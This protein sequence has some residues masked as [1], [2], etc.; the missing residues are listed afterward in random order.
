MVTA[1]GRDDEQLAALHAEAERCLLAGESGPADA[2]LQA[3]SRR[4]RRRIRLEE[5]LLFPA[6]ADRASGAVLRMRREHAVLMEL[7]TG[8]ERSFGAGC[9]EI[10]LGDLREM[11]AALRT[12]LAE[13]RRT[14]HPLIRSLGGPPNGELSAFMDDIVSVH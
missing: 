12:H 6:L 7:L 2:S 8:V 9:W 5:D 11:G 1:L 3:F 14:L 13:E 10:A 4:L